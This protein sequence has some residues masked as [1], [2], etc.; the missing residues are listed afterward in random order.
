[1]KKSVIDHTYRDY[2]QTDITD[3]PDDDRQQT[4]EELFP[5]KLHRILNTPEYEEII[6]WMPHGRVW[7][8]KNKSVF[9]SYILPR[10]FQHS[11]YESFNRSVNGWGMK[12]SFR[13]CFVLQICVR[14]FL[15]SKFLSPPHPLPQRLYQDGPDQKGYYHELFLR[16]KID[17]CQGM[18][19]LK[20]P[21]KRLPK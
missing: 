21:G 6:S 3:F 9:V 11:N 16:G 8:V 5:A 13:R 14:L 17:L 12:V 2:S 19:R 4:S 20:A 18:H 15:S 7:K 1:M 10:H